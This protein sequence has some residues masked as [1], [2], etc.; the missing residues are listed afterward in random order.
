MSDIKKTIAEIDDLLSKKANEPK[1]TKPRKPAKKEFRVSYSYVIP[2]QLRLGTHYGV[3]TVNAA[4]AQEAFDAIDKK[5]GFPNGTYSASAAP[6]RRGQ[7]RHEEA[8]WFV[9]DGGKWD[10]RPMHQ[11]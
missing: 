10:P 2:G 4:T 8:K 7:V 11:R 5:G 9:V 6:I 1:A 3:T